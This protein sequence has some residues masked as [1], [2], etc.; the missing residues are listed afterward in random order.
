MCYAENAECQGEKRGS[1]LI[2][3]NKVVFI[4]CVSA[5]QA[6][7]NTK[8]IKHHTLYQT[9]IS[10]GVAAYQYS[11][12]PTMAATT[13]T[14]SPRCWYADEDVWVSEIEEGDHGDHPV[15]HLFNS[16]RM[17]ITGCLLSILLW[18]TGGYDINVCTCCLDEH[19]G[20]MEGGEGGG[21]VSTAIRQWLWIQW[22]SQQGTTCCFSLPLSLP[23]IATPQKQGVF[24][25]ALLPE[26]VLQC[27]PWIL[28]SNIAG[29]SK[30]ATVPKYINPV[31]LWKNWSGPCWQLE[32]S[33]LVQVWSSRLWNMIPGICASL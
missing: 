10:G 14:L 8:I 25:H 11:S 20:W 3:S 16:S 15:C 33:A 21:V 29:C 17:P 19:Q 23:S 22:L 6:A 2:S 13:T 32:Q 27:D 4:L 7:N 24:H 18:L 28:V 12:H 9:C 30:N 5:S 1:K 26:A 31:P